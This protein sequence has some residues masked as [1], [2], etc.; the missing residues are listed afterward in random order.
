MSKRNR[1]SQRGPEKADRNGTGVKAPHQ[2][3][4]PGNRQGPK[5]TDR[6]NADGPPASGKN[7]SHHRGEDDHPDTRGER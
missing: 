7:A 3:R 4:S 2:H 1:N 5:I 6:T